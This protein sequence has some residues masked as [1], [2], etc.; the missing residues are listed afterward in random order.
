[1]QQLAL[2]QLLGGAVIAA[3]SGKLAS[4]FEPFFRTEQA[5]NL[6]RNQMNVKV[7]GQEHHRSDLDKDS[8]KM[9]KSWATEA[10]S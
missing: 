2:T 4:V 1:M 9:W 10:G 3:T 5:Q 6:V 8:L 7:R